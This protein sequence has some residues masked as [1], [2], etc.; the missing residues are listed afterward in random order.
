M[1]KKNNYDKRHLRNLT[2]YELRIDEIYRQA[3]QEAARI[4][5]QIRTVKGDGIFSFRDYPATRKRVAELMSGLQRNVLSVV[6]NGIDAEWTLANNKNNELARQVFGKK[7]GQLSQAQYRRYFSTNDSARQA[8]QA[9]RVGGLNLSERVWRYANQFKEEIELGLDLGIRNGLSADQMSRDLRDYLRHPDKLFRR[10]RDEHGILQLSKRAKEFHPGA[11]VY[12]SSYRN[13]RRLASTEANIAY[14]TSDHTRWQQFDFVVGI[15]VRLSNNHTCLGADGKPHE[16]HDICDELAGRYPKDF[17]FT[18]WHP[19]CRCHA[20]S[21]LKTQEEIAEDTRRIMNGEPTDGNSVNRV[22]SV[23]EAFNSW[24][25]DNKER[26]K[27]WSSMPYFVRDNPQYVEGFEVDTYTPEER[28]FTRARSTSAAMDESLGIYLSSRYPEIPNTEK[29][30]LF[31][32]TRGDTSAYRRLNKEL[33]K[34]ELSEFNQAFSSLLSKALDKIEPVQA[35]VYRTV[36]LNRTNLRAWVNQ[37]NSQ[38]EVTFS[39]FTSTSLDRS[40]IENMIQAKS[41]GRKKNESDVLL[42]IQSKTGHPIQDFSQFGGRF[43]GKANQQEVLFDKGR[44]FRFDRV[45]QEGDRFVFY[46]SEV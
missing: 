35:T 27:G 20:V 38:A 24:I 6:V 4:G 34:G 42:V 30:S 43:D 44:R 37:A 21:I 46:L 9:R 3:I 12:R 29:A 2:V 32:Y 15:E 10:V 23:P 17:K 1:A 5:S 28:K 16:F 11:G 14:R 19:H 18:G 22:D 8:F 39:G 36:R 7:V 25:A 40:V 33:R 45:A 26:A 13:A 41:E 31:H